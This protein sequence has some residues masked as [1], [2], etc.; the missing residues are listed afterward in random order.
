MA[1]N[2]ILLIDNL[3]V[4]WQPVTI[5]ATHAYPR[6]KTIQ[7][8]LRS[9]DGSMVL[10]ID[11]DKKWSYEAHLLRWLDEEEKAGATKCKL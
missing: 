9:M 10:D 3:N 4:E 5:Q 1:Y 6:D 2:D 8:T 11:I 7:Y